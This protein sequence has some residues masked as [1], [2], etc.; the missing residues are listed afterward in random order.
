MIGAAAWW[1]VLEHLWTSDTWLTKTNMQHIPNPVNDC[2]SLPSFILLCAKSNLGCSCCPAT[3]ACCWSAP[4]KQPGKEW[5]PPLCRETQVRNVCFASTRWTHTMNYSLQVPPGGSYQRGWTLTSWRQVARC[6]L[7][8][9]DPDTLT[10]P[11]LHHKKQQRKNS[12]DLI[13]QNRGSV[14]NYFK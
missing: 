2:V 1:H 5:S 4:A 14:L 6:G 9:G 10:G 8:T 3:A 13:I 7:W 11:Q 12:Q